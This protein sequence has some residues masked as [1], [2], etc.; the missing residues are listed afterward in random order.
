ME[1]MRGKRATIVALVGSIASIAPPLL[2]AQTKTDPAGA[3]SLFEE[4]KKLEAEDKWE[5]ACAKFAASQKLDP[6]IGTLLNLADCQEHVGKTATAWALFNEGAD[7]AAQAGQTD[8][9]AKARQ[10]AKDLEPKLSRLTIVVKTPIDGLE[11]LRDGIALDPAVLGTAVPVDPGSHV[12]AARA[13]NKK[14]WT[15]T[16]E[17]GANAADAHVE[18]PALDAAPVDVAPIA[19]APPTSTTSTTTQPV[20]VATTSDRGATQRTVGWILGGA[21]LVGLAVGTA[22]GLSASSKWSSA[23]SGCDDTGCPPDAAAKT[24]DARHAATA[25][26]VAFVAG[27]VLLAAGVIVLWTAPSKEAGVGVA[28]NGSGWSLQVGGS[29]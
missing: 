2:R 13:P 12:V 6:G 15:T 7:L 1:L 22:F 17:V 3:Q 5:E 8:R 18:V 26:T 24:D 29:F 25:S 16:I 28:S 9:A 4:A 19:V 27:G 11:V 10:R 14:S 23:K 20:D 21:G